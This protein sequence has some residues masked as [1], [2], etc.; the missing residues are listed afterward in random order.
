MHIHVLRGALLLLPAAAAA[1]RRVPG[2]L[3]NVR[4]EDVR[5]LRADVR[6][7]EGVERACAVV[8]RGDLRGGS[9]RDEGSEPA[10]EGRCC[11]FF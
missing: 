11:A 8:V 4:S 2:T 10:E 6:F 3:D 1:R 9:E 5:H 7:D